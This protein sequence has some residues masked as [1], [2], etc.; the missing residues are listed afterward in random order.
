M[1]KT[2]IVVSSMDEWR[3]YAHSDLVV[4][5][6]EY[7]K[8][9]Q[10]RDQALQLI[11]LAGAYDYL[12]KG[13]YCTLLAEARG[14]KVLPSLETLGGFN[15]PSEFRGFAGFPFIS[16]R[17]RRAHRI[18]EDEVEIFV[19]FGMTA[20]SRFEAY[21]KNL[22]NL[23]NFPLL[24]VRLKKQGD[25]RWLIDTV[26]PVSL[27][28]LV[29]AEQD[30]FVEALE[31]YHHRIWYRQR[32]RKGNSFDLAMLHNPEE[33]FPPSNRR[34]LQQFMA[35]AKKLDIHAELITADDF[36]RLA[37]FDAL[38][39]RETTAVN[40]HTYSFAR[41]AQ[42]LGLE[43]IDDPASILRCTNKVYLHDLLVKNGIPAPQTR[44]LSRG[45]V[46]SGMLEGMT[47][48]VVL[49]IPDGSFSRGI[50]RADS[51]AEA[52]RK[53][54]ELFSTSHLVLAQQYLYT[55]FDWRIGILNHEPL[56]ACR[57]YMAPG[58][59]Q[60]Y[61][62]SGKHAQPGEAEALPLRVVPTSVLKIA[63]RAGDLIGNG[64]YGVDIKQ[65]GNECFVIEVNDNPN[66]DYGVE[67]A[68]IGDE[69][70]RSVINEFLRRL[71]KGRRR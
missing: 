51:P 29:P 31:R 20:D 42:R 43:V 69:L 67:D 7:L 41:E 9:Y 50:S 23:M 47:Y 48:P 34:A 62:H 66:I 3:D 2:I 22:F 55:E 37:E 32:S 61:T 12:G 40:H 21:A 53:L 52:S 4:D 39:I 13:Y 10:E 1:A 33:A 35:A 36:R 44:V 45:T 15:Q 14:H 5:F 25:R 65:V 18:E 64:L 59:W 70:Y 11:N 19:V 68:I 63:Q 57:Y 46:T 60:I 27:P 17:D 26:L 16:G 30:F 6:E 24:K 38:F 71:W 49:K 56:F 54:D 58:H 28:E 8:R